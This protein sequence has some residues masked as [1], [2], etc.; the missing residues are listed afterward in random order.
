MGTG[1]PSCANPDLSYRDRAALVLSAS[2][3]GACRGTHTRGQ[4]VFCLCVLPLWRFGPTFMQV[5]RTRRRSGAVESFTRSVR[6][7]SELLPP[8]SLPAPTVDGATATYANVLPGRT[9]WLPPMSKAAC[10]CPPGGRLGLQRH[11]TLLI[12]DPRDRIRQ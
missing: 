4:A 7:P 5:I 12:D 2:A 6:V 8:A 11:P 10:R 3:A 1:S 9:L